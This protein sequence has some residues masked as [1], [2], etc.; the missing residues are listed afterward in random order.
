[1][2][3][4]FGDAALDDVFPG[5]IQQGVLAGVH[6]DAHFV[7]LDEPSE[8]GELVGEVLLPA[9]GHH[10]MRGEGNGIRRDPE[11]ADVMV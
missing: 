7:A 2:V 4:Q 10:R 6:V 5:R 11:E 9:K 1:M 3:D 8:C